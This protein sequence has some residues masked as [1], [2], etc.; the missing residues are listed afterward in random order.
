MY[1]S[2]MLG[3]C[4]VCDNKCHSVQLNEETD[5]ECY[6]S[7]HCRKDIKYCI[8]PSHSEDSH[9]WFNSLLKDFCQPSSGPLFDFLSWGANISLDTVKEI[10]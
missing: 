8:N 10:L 5:Q 9:S 2:V 1:S 3:T 6:C 4:Y 7:N